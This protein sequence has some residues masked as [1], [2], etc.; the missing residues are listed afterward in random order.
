[1]S[2]QEEHQETRGALLRELCQWVV[3]RTEPRPGSSKPTKV[4]YSPISGRKADSTAPRTWAGYEEAVEARRKHGYDGIGFVF[5]KDDPYCGVDLDHCRNPETGEIESWAQEIISEL[6]SYTEISPSGDGVHIILRGTLPPGRNRKGDFET[7]DHARYFS[8]TGKHLAGTPK[9]VESRQEQLENVVGRVFR[10]ED[11]NDNEKPVQAVMSSYSGLPDAEIIEKAHGAVNGDKFWRLWSGYVTDHGSHSEADLALCSMLAFWVGGDDTRIDS[12]FRQSGL[13]RQKWERANYRTRTI[14]EAV[15]GQREFYTPAANSSGSSGMPT[16]SSNSGKTTGPHRLTDYGNAERLVARHGK[17]LRYCYAWGKWLVWDDRRW[18]LDTTGEV[19][20]R[21]KETVRSIYAEAA[22]IA[23]EKLRA[24]IAK[25]ANLSESRGKIEAM[26]AH[27]RSEPGIPLT[28]E[29]LDADP[30]LFNVVNGTLN[31]RTGELREHDRKDLIT[32]ISPVAYDPDARSPV[33]DSVLEKATGGDRELEAFLRRWAGYCLTGDTGEEKIVF[34]HG[35]AATAKSTILEAMKAAWGDY[36]ATADFEAFLARRE[37][38]GPRNDIARLAGKRL[39]VSIEVDEGKRLAEGLV[40]MLTGGDTVTARFLYQEAFEFAPQFKLTLAANHAPQVRDDD[41]AMWRRILRVPF[42]TVIPKDERDPKVKKELK[43]PEASGPAI[44]AWAV[45][46]CREW[47]A[48]GLGVPP[49]VEEATAE[50]REDMDPLRDFIA[51]YCVLGPNFWVP[52]GQL[53]EAYEAWAREAG[54]AQIL[55]GRKW[56]E[57]LR[58]HGCTPSTGTGGLRIWTGIA[59]RNGPDEG[60]EASDNGPEAPGVADSATNENTCKTQ[61]NTQESCGFEPEIGKVPSETPHV[62]KLSNNPQLSATP[63]L[64]GPEKENPG[65][66]EE[67]GATSPEKASEALEK[68]LEDPPGWWVTQAEVVLREDSPERL[69]AP[70]VSTTA[71]EVLGSHRRHAEAREAAE[72]KLRE[73][74]GN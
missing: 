2:A 36:A 66:I 63:Q 18:A 70:L 64:G 71:S 73:M 21:A 16:T 31:L 34:S 42:E 38:G 30:G 10:E 13:Y 9:S 28:V 8:I 1:M 15:N 47:R 37:S 11:A 59:L 7:Y 58:E 32:K 72:A 3:W 24:A 41:E 55:R 40:K 53:R 49:T 12:L 69:V 25:H 26:V 39:V 68:Y 57:R 43:D 5:S 29:D 17:D 14:E 4:P 6:D 44:L 45:R 60:P 35:P 61:K 52:A 74:G 27:A 56:G 19:D 20:R 23:D 62:G 54:E 33:F 22:A 67:S 48:N 50:Y 51:D 46:G 65:S